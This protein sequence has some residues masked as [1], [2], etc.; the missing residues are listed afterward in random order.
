VTGTGSATGFYTT[1]VPPGTLLDVA[2]LWE[3]GDGATSS[4]LNASH[5]YADAGTYTVSFSARNHIGWSLPDV[6][7]VE[8]SEPTGGSLAFT[9]I[10]EATTAV[11]LS[12][13]TRTDWAIWGRDFNNS[14]TPPV[15]KSGGGSLIAA[16]LYG[17]TPGQQFFSDSPRGISWTDGAPVASA[18]NTHDGIY[19]TTNSGGGTTP[20][21]GFRLTFQ[22]GPGTNTIEVYCGTY[23]C[24]VT[25]AASVSDGSS[26]AISDTTTIDDN[27][28]D[29]E[30]AYFT[31]ECTPLSAGQTLTVDVYANLVRSGYG[32]VSLSAA[33]ITQG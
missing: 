13:P 16:A 29:G 1:I 33:A 10:A 7:D 6:E 27:P 14:L 9:A 2:Y 17:T 28:P 20:G 23:A 21:G 11:D 30:S 26:T 19:E 4:T 15:R 31:I 3:W 24:Q 12:S 8:L 18:T 22:L 25:V 32:N 5:T